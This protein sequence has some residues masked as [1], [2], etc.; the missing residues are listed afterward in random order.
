MSCVLAR[1]LAVFGLAVGLG[2]PRPAAAQAPRVLLMRPPNAGPEVN[3]ALVRVQGELVADGFAVVSV[4][5]AP[6]ATSAMAMSQAEDQA[7][8]TTVGLFL[9][10]DGSSAELWVVDTLTKKTVVR[11]VNTAGQARNAL[12]EELA[13]RTV[14]LLR[15]SLL[16]L[17]VERRHAAAPSTTQRASDWA[18]RPLVS[19]RPR[20]GI[21]TGAGMLW[22][23]GQVDPAFL[24]V[25]RGRFAVTPAWHLRLSFVGL[26]T[27][28][29]VRGTGGSASI[30][31]WC[32]LA[33]VLFVP[34]S[35][36]ALHPLFSLGAGTFH[37]AVN[38]EASAP[39]L[40]LH[41]S[42]WAFVADAGV[43]VAL[44]LASRLELAVEGH[45]QWLA[46]EPVV[47][48]V[49][50]DGASLGRPGVAGSLSLLGW[51]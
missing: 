24:S 17:V 36:F 50:E 38:G 5:A 8:A 47:R 33:E 15:A 43:G 6:G 11:H 10:A 40:G 28:P 30:A 13:V 23:P 27:R 22:S 7:S 49:N 3:A 9:N 29:R 34:F 21:E 39:Y 35:R 2:C 46:P 1:L 25:G 41:D 32:G 18:M 4:E 45:A 16:E 26:G 19:P 48:F 44:R 31:E 20:W 51:L 37:A 42:Q 12:P 14:E